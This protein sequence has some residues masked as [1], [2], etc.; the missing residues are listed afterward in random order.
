MKQLKIIKNIQQ[1][2]PKIVGINA[3]LLYGSF[4]R[5]TANFNSDI[6]I[7]ILIDEKFEQKNLIKLF[8]EELKTKI[9]R[10][11]EVSLKNKIIFYLDSSPKIELEYCTKLS[12]IN[13]NYLGSEI[14]DITKTILYERNTNLYKLESYL[15]QLVQ[16]N[17]NSSQ[18]S[19]NNLID[20]FIYEFENAS[21]MHKRSDGY[22]FYFFYNCALQA[23]VQLHH[24]SKGEN[25]FNFL[26]KNFI[27]TSLR[28]DEQNSFYDLKGSLFLPEANEQKRKLL[29]FF[30]ISI[31]KLI[32]TE[33]INELR[34]FLELVYSRDFIWNFRDI[35]T[36][37][38]IIK[39]GVIYRAATL[40]LFQNQPFFEDFINKKNIKTVIDLRAERE[41]LE[42]NYTAK[43]LK[44]IN[45]VH[46]PFDP[47]NQS[48]SFQA[49][50]HQ[51][52]NIEIAY[53][54][55][56][57]DCK[58]S[59]KQAI[60]A[61]IAEKKAVVIH[62]HAGKDRTGIFVS[63]LYLLLETN[64]D[65]I[66][67]DYLASEMDTK[68]EYLNIFLDIVQQQGGINKYLISCNLSSTQI[69][70]LKHRLIHGND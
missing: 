39:K 36:H 58:P 12:D 63:I 51:G 68:K 15:V 40:T 46:S 20:K 17:K 11:Q 62:C 64:L 49:T 56:S 44:N 29:D 70:Q 30:Y 21:T 47:W 25:Q 54:F 66:Y 48:I 38:P 50:H 55:F 37:N 45:W 59:I 33:Q 69:D 7:Q 14:T 26:P 35:S 52:T 10:S 57:I 28:R 27:S 2:F 1:F 32:P 34:Q 42:N 23:A 41:V 60:E 61:I 18:K 5:D 67:N 19:I 8:K 9:I 24:L 13:K 31:N 6:D 22:Q 4:G 53:R 43:S 65:L 16:N 3:A